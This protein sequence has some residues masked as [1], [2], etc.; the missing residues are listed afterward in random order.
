MGHEFFR[1]QG[2]D[3]VENVLE[4]DNESAIKLE[5]NGRMS[6]GPRSRHIVRYFWIKDRTKEAGIQ[7]RHCPTLQMIG[8]FFTKPLQGSLFRVFRD[9]ILG[10]KHP[11]ALAR[12]PGSSTEERVGMVRSDDS[13]IVSPVDSKPLTVQQTTVSWA[14]VVRT[15]KSSDARLLVSSTHK[16]IVSKELILSKQSRE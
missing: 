9:V 14:D 10:Y 4:Q 13:A 15:P 8:D 2:Y 1:E 6:A 16:Q 12:Y 5:T 3:I 7:I 11:D